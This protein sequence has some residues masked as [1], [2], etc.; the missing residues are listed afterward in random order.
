MSE[1]GRGKRGR[2]KDRMAAQLRTLGLEAGWNKV[3]TI[4]MGRRETNHERPGR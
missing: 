4:I 1:T 2:E 3:D